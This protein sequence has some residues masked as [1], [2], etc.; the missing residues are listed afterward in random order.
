MAA[1]PNTDLAAAIRATAMSLGIDPLDLAT[2]ISYETAGTFD[3]V[4]TGPTTQ[5]G[6]HKGFIQFGEP[7][8]RQYGVDWDNPVGS[9]LGPDG[10]VAKYLRATGV[11]PGM[12]LM[13]VYSAINAGG[14]GRYGA[15]DVN[16]GG[17]PGTVADKVNSQMGG[18]RANAQRLFGGMPVNAPD[19][20][21]GQ[22][23]WPTAAP[24][25]PMAMP[26]PAPA[27][28]PIGSML[29]GLAG[30][31]EMPAQ[32]EAPRMRPDGGDNMLPAAAMQMAEKAKGLKSAFM[33]DL[34]AILGLGKRPV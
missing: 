15:S 19:G 30:G 5:W 27:E 11:K 24:A 26:A 29:A 13:D 6:Q 7:Q 21:K 28:T 32:A 8:A 25:A 22:E 4:K 20:P 31:M 12:G 3:P 23:N 10:A 18:H 9:Q 1:N 16:N 14:V 17:A 34:D 2:A 33:P